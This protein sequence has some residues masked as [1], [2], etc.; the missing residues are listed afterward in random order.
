[1]SDV[2]AVGAIVFV[3]VIVG[4]AGISALLFTNKLRV[5]V[6]IEGGGWV[7]NVVSFLF[8]F[9]VFILLYGITTVGILILWD[10]LFL[11]NIF[12]V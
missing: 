11:L 12:L 7:A 10:K 4:T 5:G 2:E 8:W 3:A 9:V 6:H 1:M